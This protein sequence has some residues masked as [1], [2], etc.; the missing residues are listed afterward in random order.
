[1]KKTLII[2]LA[3]AA[4]LLIVGVYFFVQKSNIYNNPP[5][6]NPETNNSGANNPPS[7]GVQTFSVEINNFAFIPATLTIHAGDTVIWTN[8][9]GVLHTITSDSENELGSSSFGNGET[10]SHTFSTAGTYNYH[11][12]I[13]STMKG[14]II[15]Q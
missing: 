12:S 8:K 4:V 5:A 1:M 3:V 7:S 2:I 6:G 9:Q 14:T 11:C 10:Y 13:H 15:V